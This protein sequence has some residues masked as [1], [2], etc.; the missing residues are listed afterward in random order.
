MAQAID[1]RVVGDMLH[2]RGSS[3]GLIAGQVLEHLRDGRSVRVDFDLAVLEKSKG[4]A[5]TESKQTF[6]L[7]FDLWEQRFAVTRAG[8]L[9]RS[10]SHLTA[11]G[12]EAWCLDNLTVSLAA[13]GRLARQ[14]PFWIR[15]DYR[16]QDRAAASSSEEDSTFTLRTLIDALSRRRADQ[17]AARTLEAGPFRLGN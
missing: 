15:I 2:V 17:D 14:T 4:S 10:V 12:A 13:M 16:V 8:A 6:V 11:Q 7:S 3:I 5:V 9:P 1:V